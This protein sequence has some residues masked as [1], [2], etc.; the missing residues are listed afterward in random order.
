MENSFRQRVNDVK[1]RARGSWPVILAGLGIP[2]EVLVNRH[3]PC[4]MCGGK[5][6][7]RFDD[8]HANG[9]YYCNGCGAGNGIT[10]LE[11]YH[12][13]D[14]LTA[15]R[16]LEE[17]LGFAP[18]GATGPFPASASWRMRTLLQR[19]WEEAKPVEGGDAVAR[20]L[21]NRGLELAEFPKVL[22]THPALG[23]YERD[24]KRSRLVGRYP[25]MLAKVQAVDRR[26][27]TLHR[28][29]LAE[30]AKA[31][32]DAA[33]KFFSAGVRGA[34][35]RLY[36]PETELALAEGIETALAVHMQTGLPVWAAGSAG[37]LE[38]VELPEVVK[39]VAIFAD[40]DEHYRG[41]AAAYVLAYRLASARPR[42]AVTVYVP[43][44]PGTDFLDAYNARR[45]L[46][47]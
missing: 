12:R 9:E 14:F 38:L 34:A 26:P 27:V 25:A 10:L 46:A 13:W 22:R 21:A 18:S 32:V 3:Q 37:N 8:R 30:G 23:Y 29:Y 31:A 42:K 24:G 36:E 6:R 44:D 33:K 15:L 41:Q 1:A 28:T 4:P 39:R 7:F 40:R 19:T 16:K 2:C 43:R 20:Y 5:D 35:I 17:A 45:R 11:K 47:A